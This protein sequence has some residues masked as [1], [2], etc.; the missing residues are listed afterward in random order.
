[1]RL[2]IEAAFSLYSLFFLLLRGAGASCRSALLC[3][4]TANA[5]LSPLLRPVQVNGDACHNGDDHNYQNNILHIISD[6]A[7]TCFSSLSCAFVRS[8]TKV[9]IPTNTATTASPA[10][11][12]PTLSLDA[13]V[14]RVPMV[15]TRYA[16]VYPVPS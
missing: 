10:N 7:A 12:A 11:A 2:Q 4:R 9:I 14:I 6:H 16:T 5:L 3:I 15:Y 13:S 1:M 8:I